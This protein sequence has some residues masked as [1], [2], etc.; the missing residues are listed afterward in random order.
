MDTNNY[1]SCLPFLLRIKSK[2]RGLAKKEKINHEQKKKI[3]TTKNT[4]STKKKE[5]S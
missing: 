2:Q 1:K 4:K 5:Q 3:L